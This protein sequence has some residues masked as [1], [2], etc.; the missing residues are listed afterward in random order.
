MSK[1]RIGIIFGGI[2]SEYEVSLQSAASVIDNIP[3]EDYEVVMLGITK[4]GRW[5]YYPGDTELIRK[6]EWAQH[7]DCISAVI[8]PDR[9]HKG[10]I[11]LQ[12]D[13]SSAL[14]K[15]DCVFPVMHGAYGGED[16][17]IQGLLNLAG[18]P[19]VGCNLLSSAICLDKSITHTMLDYAKI[20]NA[21]WICLTKNDLA[22]LDNICAK[23]E[24]RFG[25]PVFVKPANTGSS[26]GINKAKNAEELTNAVKIA[27]TH[28][29]KVI[30]E[31][32]IQ[33]LEVEAAVLGTADNCIV[34]QPGHIIPANE[35]Y[36][37]D[38]KYHADSITKIPAG[39]SDEIKETIINT[40]KDV[41]KLFNCKGLSRI[42]FFVTS[43]N[44]I[45]V[46][47]IN[48]IPGFTSISMYAK[49]FE[50]SG[51]SYSELLTRLIELA[52][53]VD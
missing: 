40:A 29:E 36:D 21:S 26:V 46:N 11:K 8:S 38:A 42:D 28:D 16:G 53:K 39:I 10:I 52:I 30:I 44:N 18:I 51:I 9:M 23:A 35:F 4:R 2:S 15:L 14:L 5:L 13:G 34:A 31:Q 50:Y 7:P 32:Y 43:E 20:P 25:Y 37:Y 1:L 41:Y 49:M 24:K 33:G 27:F 19:Y 17:S 45:I 48:T 6:D 22:N 47:E 3:C 12:E